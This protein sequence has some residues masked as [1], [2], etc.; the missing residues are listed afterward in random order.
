MHPNLVHPE[1]AFLLVIDVQERYRTALEDWD[2]VAS[3]VRTLIQGAHLVELPIVYTEQYPKGL[4]STGPEILEVLANATRFEKRTISALGAPDLSTHLEQLGRREA[5]VCG[6]ET[7]A[8]INQTV[9]ALLA[10]G[11]RVHLPFDALASRH[12][13]DHEQGYRKMLA[14]GAIGSSVET[15]LLECLQSADHPAFKPVQELLK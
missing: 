4:G 2:G 7:H 14:S 15:I 3:R 9:H 11:F 10:N 6:L 13:L 12:A 1:D 5:I 8:C